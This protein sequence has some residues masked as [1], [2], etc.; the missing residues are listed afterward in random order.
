MGPVKFPLS[1]FLEA[2]GLSRNTEWWDGSTFLGDGGLAP[3]GGWKKKKKKKT[4]DDASQ[5]G[6][7]R[8]KRLCLLM[9]AARALDHALE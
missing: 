2:S 6:D 5:T 3:H 7:W 9:V 8:E 1:S 4:L